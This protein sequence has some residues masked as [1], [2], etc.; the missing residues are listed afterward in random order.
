MFNKFD[1][2]RHVLGNFALKEVAKHLALPDK[3][4]R[5]GGPAWMTTPRGNE[6]GGKP[7]DL[8]GRVKQAALYTE[9][10]LMLSY[11]PPTRKTIIK[12]ASARIGS[13][14]TVAKPI[15]RRN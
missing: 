8:A 4:R 2:V 7:R 14:G 6:V 3:A 15:M 5:Y 10:P 11:K 13:P 1:E 9:R 12:L